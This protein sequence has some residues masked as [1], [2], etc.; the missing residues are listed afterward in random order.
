MPAVDNYYKTKP[1]GIISHLLG[2]EGAGSVLSLLK[3][4]GW[5][6]GL[7][8]G[9]GHSGSSFSIFSC[10]IELSEEGLKH[11]DQIII[12][13]FQYIELLK[14]ASAKSLEHLYKEVHEISNINFRFRGKESPMNLCPSLAESMQV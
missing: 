11:V 14:H 13:V 6:N 12:I 8:A 4:K 9:V 10:G 3:R 5:A 1:H 7:N 2:H